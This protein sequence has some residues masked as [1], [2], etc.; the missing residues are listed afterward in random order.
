MSQEVAGAAGW[1][2]RAPRCVLAED[3]LQEGRRVVTESP[4]TP[5]PP[6]PSAAPPGQVF[7][8]RGSFASTSGDVS[9][10]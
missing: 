5:E 4:P 10:P 3:A 6:H 7:G 8:A 9:P 2:L 1:L